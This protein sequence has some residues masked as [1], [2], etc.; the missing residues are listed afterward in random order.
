MTNIR[1][2]GIIETLKLQ[3]HPEGGW[4]S[5]TYRSDESLK[6]TRGE[7]SLA[8]VIYFMLVNDEI[9][10]FHRLSSDEFWYY[11]EGSSLNVHVIFEDGT[12]E[13]KT[14][15]PLTAAGASPQILLPAGCWFTAEC[16]EKDSFSLMSC[17]VH[18]G[19]DFKD[20]ELADKDE[21]SNVF[22]QHRAIISKFCTE[23]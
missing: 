23:S 1:T 20:F 11:H 8:T 17:S 13:L 12:Y 14:L 16:I 7:R 18:P 2:N 6:L 15:G 10:A 9:S 19:F 22:P 3:K 21:L 4:Y 5:E